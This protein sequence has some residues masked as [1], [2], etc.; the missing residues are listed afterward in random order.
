MVYMLQSVIYLLKLKL[1]VNII[2]SYRDILVK[3]DGNIKNIDF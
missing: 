2:L 1:C 3:H